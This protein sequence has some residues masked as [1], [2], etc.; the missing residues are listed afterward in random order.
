VGEWKQS[1]LNKETNMLKEILLAASLLGSSAAMADV[2][3]IATTELIGDPVYTQTGEVYQKIGGPGG[4][5]GM[6]AA[7]WYGS[8]NQVWNVIKEQ[9]PQSVEA[10][11]SWLTNPPISITSPLIPRFSDDSLGGVLK[12][13]WTFTAPVNVITLHYGDNM[14]VWEYDQGITRFGVDFENGN[15]GMSNIR[16]YS[17]V[18]VP[19]AGLLFGSVL[20][21][22]SLVRKFIG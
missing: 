20:M 16:T 11:K 8:A 13:D 6:W 1:I 9:V 2:V 15:L 17:T 19:G 10:I 21:V 3:S 18:P 4:G 5:A 7:E 14:L 12:K 22:G